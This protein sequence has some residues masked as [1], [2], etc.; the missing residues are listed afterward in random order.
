[1]RSE[2]EVPGGVDA[3]CKEKSSPGIPGYK[4]LS[5]EPRALFTAR[6]SSKP[7]REPLAPQDLARNI[8][9]PPG[10]EKKVK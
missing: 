6:I 9:A 10:S 4:G 5:W 1:M 8:F 3:A 2:N 7:F